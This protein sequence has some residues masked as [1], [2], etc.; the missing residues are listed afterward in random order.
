MLKPW[1]PVL[2]LLKKIVVDTFAQNSN[3]ERYFQL[4]TMRPTV[5]QH[6]IYTVIVVPHKISPFSLKY[7]VV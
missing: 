4:V 3:P 7:G 1:H 2:E 6:K 5:Y